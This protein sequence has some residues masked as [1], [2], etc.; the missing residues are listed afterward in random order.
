[1]QI[2]DRGAPAHDKILIEGC[3]LECDIVNANSMGIYVGGNQLS[4]TTSNNTIGTS[5]NAFAIGISNRGA[6]NHVAKF[7]TIYAKT[8][9]VVVDSSATNVEIG[10]N[11]VQN[12]VPLAFSGHTAPNFSYYASGAFALELT[13]MTSKVQDT[14]GW[15]A[16]GRSIHLCIGGEAL[17]GSSNSSKMS[18][19]GL[20]KY[21]APILRR[22]ILTHLIDNGVQVQ[23]EASIDAEGS[24]LFAKDANVPAFTGS[25]KKGL[26]AASSMIYDL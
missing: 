12:G 15:T 10:P 17:I 14:I 9:A 3:T 25:G 20:P 18:G 13:G 7:N 6:H 2:A 21:L 22:S 11:V 23:G 1:V 16:N 8:N 26:S 19:L 5:T 4:V 24:I